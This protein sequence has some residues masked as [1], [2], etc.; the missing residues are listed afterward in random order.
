MN[1]NV[2]AKLAFRPLMRSVQFHGIRG[3]FRHSSCRR[4]FGRHPCLSVDSGL[5]T[6]GM[7]NQMLHTLCI[8]LYLLSSALHCPP[9]LMK[10]QGDYQVQGWGHRNPRTEA[11]YAACPHEGIGY[12]RAANLCH[13]CL[14]IKS[15]FSITLCPYMGIWPYMGTAAGHP[16]DSN[17]HGIQFDHN[18]LA[19]SSTNPSCWRRS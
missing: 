17:C 15:I 9:F 2:T 16:P 1:V 6:A 11:Q 7:T 4:F 18:S 14:F 13:P 12:P 3:P 10:T 5:K 19:S 8:G